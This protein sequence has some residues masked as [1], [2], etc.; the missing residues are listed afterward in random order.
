MRYADSNCT[1]CRNGNDYIVKGKDRFTGTQVTVRVPAHEMFAYRQ[2]AYLQDAMVSVSDAEREFL[3]SGM[4]DSF[5]FE[6]EEDC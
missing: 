6:E 4:Y 3:L 5:P 2:G 1:I